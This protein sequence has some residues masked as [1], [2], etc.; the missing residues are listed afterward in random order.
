VPEPGVPVR[1]PPALDR[2][3]HPCRLQPSARIIRATASFPH[4]NPRAASCRSRSRS[5]RE[6]QVISAIGSPRADA[7]AS[8]RSA[9]LNPGWASWGLLPAPAARRDRPGGS[10]SSSRPRSRPP[11][12]PPWSL[13]PPPPAP[14][15]R[16]P[17]TQRPRLGPRVHP[18]RPLVRDRPHHREL[19]RQH[20]RSIFI[21]RHSA[22]W[23]AKTTNHYLIP[24]VS[25]RVKSLRDHGSGAPARTWKHA[26]AAAWPG[27]NHG[28]PRK[29]R[30]AVRRSRHAA[31]WPGESHPRAP[32][33][34][35]VKIS[36]HSARL[37]YRPFW[38][39]VVILQWENMRGCLAVSPSHHFLTF[40]NDRSRCTSVSP[41]APGRS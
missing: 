17:M 34:R 12:P 6:H 2:P 41:S 21:N 28:K 13:T 5:D 40:L 27:I 24:D 25:R 9:R 31:G 3:G 8:S 4:R 1:V 22:S 26:G 7:S 36:L 10:S 37:I 23:H 38:N 11:P 20:R 32:T 39:P 35:S 19:R 15:P 14:Q 18:P 16:S 30:E 29:W 33:E